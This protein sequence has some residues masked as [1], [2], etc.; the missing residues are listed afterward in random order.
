MTILVNATKNCQCIEVSQ[1]SP[2]LVVTTQP[3]RMVWADG[4]SYDHINCANSFSADSLADFFCSMC[5]TCLPYCFW[6]ANLFLILLSPSKKHKPLRG[7]FIR[8]EASDKFRLICKSMFACMYP[9]NSPC[10]SRCH[11]VFDT[12]STHKKGENLTILS[13]LYGAGRSLSL[14]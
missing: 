5:C 1:A 8:L 4:N 3:S 11:H 7:A 2:W 9:P 13:L 6:I 12:L 10:P 14:E